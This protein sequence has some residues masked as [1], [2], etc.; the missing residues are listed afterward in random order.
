MKKRGL[1]SDTERTSVLDGTKSLVDSHP[2]RRD[3]PRRY[4]KFSSIVYRVS[5]H[6][7][8][9]LRGTYTP[10]KRREEI[11]FSR[12]DPRVSVQGKVRGYWWGSLV[13][14]LTGPKPPLSCHMRRPSPGQVLQS[15]FERVQCVPCPTVEESSGWRVPRDQRTKDKPVEGR[16]TVTQQLTSKPSFLPVISGGVP[17]LERERETLRKKSFRREFRPPRLSLPTVDSFRK[18]C[19]KFTGFPPSSVLVLVPHPQRPSI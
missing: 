16:D 11:L 10:M 15:G 7:G 17:S 2:G 3:V 18:P 5:V 1:P 19:P 14:T 8:L 12:V 6:T 4:R 9:C 13:G